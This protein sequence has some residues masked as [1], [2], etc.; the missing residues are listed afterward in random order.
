MVRTVDMWSLSQ[1]RVP[2]LGGVPII[3]IVTKTLGSG[4][5][6]TPMQGSMPI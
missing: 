6:P 5:V 4:F 2:C 3:R 1:I